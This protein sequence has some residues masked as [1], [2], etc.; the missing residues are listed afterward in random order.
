MISEIV[1]NDS[2]RSAIMEEIAPLITPEHRPALSPGELATQLQQCEILN[3]VYNETLRLTS[4]STSVRFVLE[5]SWL[6][7]F[8]LRKGTRM[9]IPYRQQ[10]LNDKTF[11]ED[12]ANFN[13][14]RFL[15]D[16]SLLKNPNYRPFGGGATLCP[17]KTLAQKEMLTFVALALG[18][19]QAR[20][21]VTKEQ[22]ECSVPRMNT[23]TP[24]IG[25]MGPVDA[26]NFC[27]TITKPKW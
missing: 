7:G 19:F 15:K 6:G 21:P 12:Y 11:G 4:A 18:K 17:G 5:D 1:R 8:K 26:E 3:S 14:E 2:L 24:C 16:P 13:S 27:V 10:M 20:L 23:W 25:V 9:V 22:G